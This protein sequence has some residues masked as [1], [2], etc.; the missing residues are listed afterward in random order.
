MEHILSPN[1]KSFNDKIKVLNQTNGRQLTLTAQEAKNL[2]AEIF[3]LLNHFATVGRIE[4]SKNPDEVI[5]VA[6]DGGGF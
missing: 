2:H 5:T 1:L 4:T 6:M 3:D